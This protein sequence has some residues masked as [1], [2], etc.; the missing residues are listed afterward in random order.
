MRSSAHYSPG[1]ASGSL[2]LVAA[3]FFVGATPSGEPIGQPARE[4][5]NH[6]DAAILT[7]LP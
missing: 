3:D 1:V 6:I 4:N 7:G 5:V 2:S